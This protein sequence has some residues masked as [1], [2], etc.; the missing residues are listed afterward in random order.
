[1]NYRKHLL[2][3]AVLLFSFS[4]SAED[5]L[6]FGVKAGTAGLGAEITWRPV[7]WLD[8]RIGGNMY[9]YDDTGVKSG[10]NYDATLALESFY[11]TFNFRFPLSP[12][13][14]SLGAYANGN[15]MQMVSQDLATY[16]IGNNPTPYAPADVGSLQST[17]SFDDVAP[18]VG[19]GFDFELFNRLG[20]TLDFG[21][22]WQGDPTVTLTADGLLASD[23]GFQ[24][25]LEVERQQ[26]EDDVKDMKAYPIIAL[27]FNFNF[28]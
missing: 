18:Y 3:I 14:L 7:E 1:M 25:D 13:R 23:P 15:E 22:L 9:D 12:F 17:T 16:D 6:W 2:S 21:V 11:S 5:N 28:F 19:A 27:G 24:A 26:L 8:W 20:L 4:A 10:I